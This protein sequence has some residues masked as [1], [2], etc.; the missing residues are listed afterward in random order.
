[1]K[2]LC[3]I[4][5]DET[6]WPKLSAADMQMMMAEYREFSGGIQKSGQ[7]LG[8]NR[9][10][11]THTATTVRV[12]NGKLST[13]DGPFAE[14]KE[15]LGGFFLIE[16]Q[17]SER[18]DPGRVADPRR[19]LRLHRGAT[20]RRVAAAGVAA[21]VHGRRCGEASSRDG[22]SRLPRRVAPRPRH[23]DP[24]PR[25][26]RP[27]RGG[28]ARRLPRRARAMARATACR[29]NPRAWLVSA[30]RFKAI[31]ALR[32][33]A[34]FDAVARGTR[35]RLDAAA[36]RAGGQ[37]DATDDIED[38]RLRL[39]FTCCHP[40]LPPDAQ[41]A[42]TLREV[43]G[44]TTEEIAR[45]FLAPAPTDRAAHRA[46]QGEDPRCR[47]SPTRCRRAPSCPTASTPCCT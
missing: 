26:L 27:R 38:D 19:A 5:S 24:P 21:D 41:V 36:R 11:P 10:Q 18:G 22:R 13:T 6:Q 16:A 28:A 31:D 39:I 17:G 42:L 43:C 20:D 1:M 37:H 47:A 45:A 2:Y 8:S 30:G 40:A 3:L 7:Y 44:L 46:R 4:Y 12:R 9:L 23:A 29:R 15:Q 25:R 32:R 14:T 33:R 35:R 34:R